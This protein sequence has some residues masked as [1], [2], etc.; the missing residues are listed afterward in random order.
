MLLASVATACLVCLPSLL[1]TVPGILLVSCLPTLTTLSAGLRQTGDLLD[2]TR[3]HFYHWGPL[4]A[5]SRRTSSWVLALC[6]PVT[7]LRDLP[8]QDPRHRLLFLASVSYLKSKYPWLTHQDI[9][10][11]LG[12]QHWTC[13]L[14]S[15]REE[16]EHSRAV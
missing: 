11:P 5:L 7:I 14:R 15:P 6:F 1:Q 10:R 8:K 3:F 13:S 4:G 12:Q 9:L 2:N 16:D